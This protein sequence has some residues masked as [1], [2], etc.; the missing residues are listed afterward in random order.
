MAAER[1][2]DVAA[3]RDRLDAL[4]RVVAQLSASAPL[5]TA[6]EPVAVGR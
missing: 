1:F 2:A 6:P 3:L 4:Q 5:E